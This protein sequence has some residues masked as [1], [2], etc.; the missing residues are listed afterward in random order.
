M[1]KQPV[2]ILLAAGQSHRFGGNKLLHPVIDDTPMLMV[3]AQK[4]ASVLPDSI[5]VINQTLMSYTTQLEKLGM[6]VVIN[7]QAKQGIGTSIACGI[8][9][10]QD[11][12]GW[13]ITLTDMPCIKTETI[14]LL[15]RQLNN[16]ADIVAPVFEQQRGHPVGFNQ[17]Y[18]DELLA[19][20]DDIGARQIIANHQHQLELVPTDDS[21]VITDIDKTS[22]ISA[23]DT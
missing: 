1:I 15:A 20:N 6:R 19:L 12:S 23:L 8:H 21:G 22:D 2:G 14:T 16:G 4:L 11:A 3:S 5:I 9:A 7:E 13:L 17:R 18:K 10:S